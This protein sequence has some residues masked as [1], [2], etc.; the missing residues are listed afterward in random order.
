MGP[1]SLLGPS[2][3][4]SVVKECVLAYTESVPGFVVPSLHYLCTLKYILLNADI[5]WGSVSS[6][7]LTSACLHDRDVYSG[8]RCVNC[9]H[10]S[11]LLQISA[12]LL[13][14]IWTC[15]V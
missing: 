4:A 9:K 7:S 2:P 6:N 3:K 13:N 14:D 11:F 10:R 5:E 15:S 8:S 1:E 12:Q